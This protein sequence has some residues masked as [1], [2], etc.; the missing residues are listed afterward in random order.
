MRPEF[1]TLHRDLPREGPGSA[2]EVAWVLDRIAPPARVL[3]LAC[4]P[5][6]DTVEL[7]QRLPAARIEAV[8]QVR[9]FVEAAQR[10]TARF[11][12]RVTVRQ[13]D[14]RAV[15]GQHDLIWC[16]GAVYF[17]GIE[18]ALPL[19]R[20]ALAPG[21]HLAFTEPVL[22]ETPASATAAAF[23]GDHP[24]G[25]AGAIAGRVAA[26]GYRTLATRLLTGAPWEDY[27]APLERR[28][29]ALR[30]GASAAL[31]QVLDEAER[32]VTLWR[33]A[34]DQIAYLLTLAAPA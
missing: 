33:R 1:F 7:A 17:L 29:A 18:A 32:E 4:G 34:P 8:E 12:D 27:Y 24:V 6:A 9:H 28:I 15:T 31:T 22:V 16:M 19:W 14:M 23:W 13:G 10:A 2:A 21:G 3:D 11:G 25:D 5:G 30:P 20:P 26:A